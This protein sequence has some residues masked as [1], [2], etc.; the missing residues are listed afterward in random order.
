MIELAIVLFGFLMYL[1]LIQSAKMFVNCIKDI[2]KT[3]TARHATMCCLTELV[4][5][6]NKT[7]K[8]SNLRV[9]DN[10]DEVKVLGELKYIEK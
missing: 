1:G 2:D 10:T 5:K 8:G 4:D 7:F 3:D 6:L 9:I